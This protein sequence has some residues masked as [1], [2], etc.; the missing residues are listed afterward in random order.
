[1]GAYPNLKHLNYVPDRGLQEPSCSIITGSM[2]Q[3]LEAAYSEQLLRK[4]IINS[5][6]CSETLQLARQNKGNKNS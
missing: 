2:L 6:T 4:G 1:M 3:I 5:K